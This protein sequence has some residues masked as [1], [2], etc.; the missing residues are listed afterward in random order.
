QNVLICGNDTHGKIRDSE[1][2]LKRSIAYDG[3]HFLRR[4]LETEEYAG[5]VD[6]NFYEIVD[7]KKET[8]LDY[9]DKIL[10]DENLMI[11]YDKE[12]LEDFIDMIEDSE[13]KRGS[14]LK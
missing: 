5:K 10:N 6:Y 11:V 4:I 13:G 7:G 12:E 9:I 14:E 1:H 2:I 8:I 3:T